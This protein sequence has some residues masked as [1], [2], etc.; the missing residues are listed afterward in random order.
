MKATI[1]PA[2]ITTIED[3]IAGNLSF[4]QLMLFVFP[5]ILMGLLFIFVPP[6]VKVNALKLV[7]GGCLILVGGALAIR[8]KGNLVLHRLITRITN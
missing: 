5:V 7:V 3:R 4:T 8:Y 2:Q 6:L 1:V